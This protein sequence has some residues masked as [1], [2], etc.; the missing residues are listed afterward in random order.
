[1]LG[2]VATRPA[3]KFPFRGFRSG[4]LDVLTAIHVMVCSDPSRNIGT[5]ALYSCG[6]GYAPGTSSST[7]TSNYSPDITRTC[8]PDG[9]WDDPEPAV[10]AQCFSNYC[11]NNWAGFDSEQNACSDMCGT[12]SNS[13]LGSCGP[14]GSPQCSY[15][16]D[17]LGF[18]GNCEC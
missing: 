15:S 10:C 13:M 8:G 2:S 6:D 11:I 1:M 16:C 14:C 17:S 9:T 12:G 4:V 5:T 7:Y 3:K 18:N